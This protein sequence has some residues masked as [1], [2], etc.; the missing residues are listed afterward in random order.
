MQAA[1]TAGAVSALAYEVLAQT[2]GA[3]RQ[4][5]EAEFIMEQIAGLP[6]RCRGDPK[7]TVISHFATANGIMTFN[8]RCPPFD[9]PTIRRALLGAIDQAEVT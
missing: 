7:I 4:T 9:N 6:T 3:K 2:T 8:H 1:K 5:A